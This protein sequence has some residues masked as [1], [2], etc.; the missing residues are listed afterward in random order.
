MS[1]GSLGK[2]TSPPGNCE[3]T[4]Q[5][6]VA[7][8]TLIQF[9]NQLQTMQC[10]LNST[11]LWYET[12]KHVNPGLQAFNMFQRLCHRYDRTATKPSY[13][14]EVKKCGALTCTLYFVGRV[15][16]MQSNS[17]RG[18]RARHVLLSRLISFCTQD[19]IKTIK[20]KQA[21]V[22]NTL[23]NYVRILRKNKEMTLS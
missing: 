6:M 17:T 5:E 2:R 10:N 7:K 22:N 1:V 3:I 16:T 14:F 21:N 13:H 23:E 12:T 9:I 4:A 18:R 8:A 15:K 20:T 11:L 19:L